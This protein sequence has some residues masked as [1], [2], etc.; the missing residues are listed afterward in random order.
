MDCQSWWLIICRIFDR[1]IL[2]AHTLKWLVRVEKKRREYQRI[3]KSRKPNLK[4]LGFNFCGWNT[5]KGSCNPHSGA[6]RVC[7]GFKRDWIGYN[8]IWTHILC[9]I[10]LCEWFIFFIFVVACQIPWKIWR[11]AMVENT[12]RIGITH[13]C[14]GILRPCMV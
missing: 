10:P 7:L 2:R 13:V 3:Y 9:L 5:V 14:A 12:S 8:H 6:L 1:K 11:F 4:G